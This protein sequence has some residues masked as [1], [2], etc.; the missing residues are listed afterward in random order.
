MKALQHVRDWAANMKKWVKGITF[1]MPLE[2]F[3]VVEDSMQKGA[4]HQVVFGKNSVLPKGYYTHPGRKQWEKYI[5]NGQ[6]NE[7]IVENVPLVAGMTENDAHLLYANSDLGYPDTKAIFFS[8]DEKFRKWCEDLV[9]YYW[10]LPEVKNA[11][12]LEQ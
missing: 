4:T 1:T 2:Y 11:R 7:K 9:D 5:A 3:E 6:V 12:L 8:K 10:S